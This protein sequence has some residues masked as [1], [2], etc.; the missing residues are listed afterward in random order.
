MGRTGRSQNRFERQKIERISTPNIFIP[1]CNSNG[2]TPPT[3]AYYT[4]PPPPLR[5]LYFIV[6]KIKPIILWTKFTLQTHI[7]NQGVLMKKV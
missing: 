7:C 1:N 5:L 6:H 2:K 4:P 3:H